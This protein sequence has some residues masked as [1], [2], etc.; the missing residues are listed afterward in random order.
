MTSSV[1]CTIGDQA[2]TLLYTSLE[3]EWEYK[4]KISVNTLNILYKRK[5]KNHRAI[6]NEQSRLWFL[7]SGLF[8]L[9]WPMVFVLWI[10]HSWLPYGFCSLDCSFLIAQCCMC[11]WIVHSW[12]PYGF[13]SYAYIE[14]SVYLQ[15]FFF[16]IPIRIPMKYIT[17]S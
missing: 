15:I 12:L 1:L 10:I 3:Y 16:Y 5:N 11:L 8:I 9:D 7:F 17:E 6:T 4:K 13:C 2:T 14:C